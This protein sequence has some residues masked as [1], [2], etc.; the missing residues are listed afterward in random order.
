MKV[1]DKNG[2]SRIVEENVERVEGKNEVGLQTP[3]QDRCS[4]REF[5][6]DRLLT[7]LT[8]QDTRSGMRRPRLKSLALIVCLI[9]LI[10]LYTTC[11]D[12]HRIRLQLLGRLHLN[13]ILNHDWD[14]IFD[15]LT[16]P[17]EI[18]NDTLED[19][20]IPQ[21][22]LDYAPLVH[23]Y[24]EE[25][26]WPCD[27]AE[28]LLHVTPELDY[29]PIQARSLNMNLTNLDSLN[30]YDHG[31]HVYLT[32][33]D[34]VEERPDW[35]G[36]QKNIPDDFVEESEVDLYKRSRLRLWTKK[37]SR[38]THGGR[39]DAPAVLV[40]VEKGR[41]IIDAFWFYFY[42]YN[43]GNQ[44]LNVRFGNHVGD[45]E[46]SL[47]RFQHGKPKLVFFSEHNF[48]EAYT[49]KAVEKIGKRVSSSF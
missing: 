15:A 34:N 42:S 48:G 19:H 30:Q 13:E 9:G 22:V 38:Q 5:G 7:C 24:S 45:W 4:W 18:N 41:G 32:S 35:L 40:M 2:A 39:S 29:T 47:I 16:R 6:K 1:F 23:L 37:V 25:K 17:E 3:D 26:F 33:D 11:G 21:Y 27:M 49:Y 20:R 14:G 31:R 36:G 44:V 12:P 28:H 43:L 10:S 46:H 8:V